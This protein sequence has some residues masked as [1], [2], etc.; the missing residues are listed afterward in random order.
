[1]E[2]VFILVTLVGSFI[3]ASPIIQMYIPAIPDESYTEL[4]LLGSTHKA[5][6]YPYEINAGERYDLY[7]VVA[8]HRGCSSYYQLL[9]K[10]RDPT[11]PPPNPVEGTPSDQEAFHEYPIMMSDEE[12]WEQMVTFT[13][14]EIILEN[15]Q[16]HITE[17]ILNENS[18]QLN[19]T[20]TWNDE[21]G[22]NTGLF[23]EL[24]VLNETSSVVEYDNRFV[25]IWLNVTSPM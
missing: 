21:K 3:I 5:N 15:D 14:P 19:K 6:D 17:I 2:S 23:F 8:N 9:A 24:W 20:L 10:I 18:I 25:E 22:Y 7:I 13:F 12:T 11:E 4:Y 16:I 1:M